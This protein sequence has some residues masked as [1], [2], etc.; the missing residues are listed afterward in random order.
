M[1]PRFLEPA[2]LWRC[3]EQKTSGQIC[4]LSRVEV[5]L[6][7]KRQSKMSNSFDI[8]DLRLRFPSRS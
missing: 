7:S 2:A 4:N 1:E 8:P 3:L 6:S 5:V